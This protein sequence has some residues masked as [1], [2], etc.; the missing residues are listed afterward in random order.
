[1]WTSEDFGGS[2]VYHNL[3]ALMTK[4][5]RSGENGGV[6]TVLV[7]PSCDRVDIDRHFWTHSEHGGTPHERATYPCSSRWSEGEAVMLGARAVDMG[8]GL[9]V[10]SVHAQLCTSHIQEDQQGGR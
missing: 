10:S 5:V 4:I 3:L 7:Y 8:P 2:T 1:M 6:V 9:L